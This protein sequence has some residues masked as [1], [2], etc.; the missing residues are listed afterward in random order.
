V[1]LMATTI[2]QEPGIRKSQARE[3]NGSSMATTELDA[4]A[5]RRKALTH[6]VWTLGDCI[7]VEVPVREGDGW[8]VD[9]RSEDGSQSIGILYFDL[10]G[11]LD[12]NRST[13]RETLG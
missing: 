3:A 12:E 1:I 2:R 10:G 6:T 13:N 5:I 9:L 11:D 8:K 7:R 4:R